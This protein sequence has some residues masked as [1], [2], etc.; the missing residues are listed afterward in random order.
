MNKDV[1]CIGYVYNQT[2]ITDHERYQRLPT[3]AELLELF[4]NVQNVDLA[5]VVGVVRRR[6]MRDGE[7]KLAVIHLAMLED[8][9]NIVRHR[10]GF[11]QEVCREAF[12]AGL[13][14]YDTRDARKVF[15]VR[16]Q[17]R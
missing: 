16:K 8:G 1:N 14:A 10:P 17:E 9:G 13:W 6:A 5:E 7:E 4:D 15:L 2:G 12:G 11:G 3:L